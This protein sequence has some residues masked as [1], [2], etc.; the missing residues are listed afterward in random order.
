MK[1]RPSIAPVR[2]QVYER[3]LGVC[4]ICNVRGDV[5]SAEELAHLKAR[6]MGGSRLLDTTHNTIMACIECHRGPRS[7]HSGH[8]KYEFLTDQG[9]DGPMA[10]T[11]YEKL[12]KA[13]I[14]PRRARERAAE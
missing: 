6:G 10:F 5:S 14:A 1:R 2:E 7:L 3:D 8:I 11:R 9:A 13:E 12:P 4:R